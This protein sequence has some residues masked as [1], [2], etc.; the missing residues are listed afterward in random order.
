MGKK[1]LQVEVLHYYRTCFAGIE[2]KIPCQLIHDAVVSR[3]PAEL[4]RY[5]VQYIPRV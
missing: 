2:K 1:F 5:D 3:W 4:I